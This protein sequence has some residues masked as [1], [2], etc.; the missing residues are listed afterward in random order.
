MPAASATG[1]YKE[2]TFLYYL[3]HPRAGTTVRGTGWGCGVQ[4][5]SRGVSVGIENHLES[6][7]HIDPLLKSHLMTSARLRMMKRNPCPRVEAVPAV[8]LSGIAPKR[9]KES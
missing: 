5:V 9:S 4:C 1:H 6:G 3:G 7:L 8:L 2:I